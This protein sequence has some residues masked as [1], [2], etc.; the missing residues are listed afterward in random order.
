MQDTMVS[1]GTLKSLVSPN[2]A[3]ASSMSYFSIPLLTGICLVLVL[4]AASAFSFSLEYQT[5]TQLVAC[6]H[7][8]LFFRL[9]ALED[10]FGPPPMFC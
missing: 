2:V 7:F 6:F 5:T 9:L 3:F 10:P 8:S 4:F 1:K